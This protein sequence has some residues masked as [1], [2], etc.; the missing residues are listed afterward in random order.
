MRHGTRAM[1]AEAGGPRAGLDMLLN[2]RALDAHE[3]AI[4]RVTRRC[5]AEASETARDR[6]AR[7]AARAGGSRRADSPSGRSSSE[8]AQQVASAPGGALPRA[9]RDPRLWQ[10]TTHP[11][12]AANDPACS[13]T[14]LFSIPDR[15]PDRSSS[16]ER[17]KGQE[18]VR[19]SGPTRARVRCR[20]VGATCAVAR[21]A[22]SP[23]VQGQSQSARARV[24]RAA[25]I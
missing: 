22:A 4:G 18:R 7:G 25:T 13:I 20:R 24:Q 15:K 11:F 3:R 14:A 2:G 17:L 10:S 23:H 1:A 16:A 8:R 12:A 5:L 21:C 6:D 19:T 9:V